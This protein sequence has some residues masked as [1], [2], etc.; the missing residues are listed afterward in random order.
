M[1][2]CNRARDSIQ[3]IFDFFLCSPFKVACL[4]TI[5]AAIA[6]IIR[7]TVVSDRG[8]HLGTCNILEA[9]VVITNV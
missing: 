6:Q 7:H 8:K 1:I 9:V 3:F 2:V 4:H 5:F